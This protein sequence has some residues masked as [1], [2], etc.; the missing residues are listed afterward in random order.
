MTVSEWLASALGDG[1]EILPLIAAVAPGGG[2]IV[3]SARVSPKRPAYLKAIVPDEWVL[4]LRG[5]DSSKEGSFFLVHVPARSVP[6]DGMMPELE[7]TRPN[8]GAGV[9]D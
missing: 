1:A 8:D 7:V 3:D 5:G 6:E 9:E 4:R 2:Q